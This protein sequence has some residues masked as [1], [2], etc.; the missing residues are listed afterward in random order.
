MVYSG[1]LKLLNMHIACLK[2]QSTSP[3]DEWF[4]RFVL[5]AE[6]LSTISFDLYHSLQMS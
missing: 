4:N 3:V 5:F 1:M 6:F 2:Y